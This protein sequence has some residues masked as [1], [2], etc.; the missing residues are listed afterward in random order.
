MEPH[1]GRAVNER[2]RL[3]A[4]LCVH[5]EEARLA[6]CLEGLRFCDEIVVLLDRC[7][8]ASDSIARA[9]GAKIVSGAWP[10]EGDRRNEALAAASGDWLL[11]IDADE[12][13]TAALAREIRAVIGASSASWHRI[14]VDNYV[15]ARLVRYG[16][17][18]SFGK[19]AASCLFRRGVK[20]WE[21]QRV[22]PRIHFTGVEGPWLN[23]RLLHR[24][25]DS[26]EDMFDRFNRYTSARALD[27]R[28]GWDD[29]LARESAAR[30]VARVFARFYRCYVRREGW[31]EGP[32]GLLIALLAGLYPLV[33]H[34]KARLLAEARR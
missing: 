3:S 22:H 30:N 25:D 16:W 9:H 14:P 17:G 26:V 23:E 33:S 31:R 24:V 6:R 13:V 11:E 28:D 20:R 27:L 7:T 2:P 18:G 5:N 21:R 34:L 1:G 12:E 29:G 8:D 10:I 19:S 32:M 15:G 4:V